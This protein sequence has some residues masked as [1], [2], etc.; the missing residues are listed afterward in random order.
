MW[1]DQFVSLLLKC[2]RVAIARWQ[3]TLLII[4]L[5]AAFI[6]ALLGLY[7]SE[8]RLALLHDQALHARRL[9]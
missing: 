8:R 1:R 7:N 3:V 6:G 9:R 4:A 5:P 2:L